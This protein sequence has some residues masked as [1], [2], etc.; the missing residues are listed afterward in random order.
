MG[1]RPRGIETLP[2]CPVLSVMQISHTRWGCGSRLLHGLFYFQVV[3]IALRMTS[4]HYEYSSLI[5]SLAREATITGYPINRP[6]WWI[7]PTDPVAQ[8]VDTRNATINLISIWVY[9]CFICFCFGRV[10]VGRR[11]ARGSCFGERSRDQRCLLANRVM[12]R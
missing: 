6:I 11:C 10:S 1:L 7:D 5:I 12:A 3:D 2:S 9:R 8:T 4:L